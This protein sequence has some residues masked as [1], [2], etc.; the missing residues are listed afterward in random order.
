VSV[1]NS[2]GTYNFNPGLGEEI[3][4]AFQLCGIRPTALTQQHFESARMAANMV[5][6]RFSSD[7]VN[8]WQ[9]QQYS[10]PLVQGCATYP[11]PTN[12]IVMLDTYYTICSGNNEIDR[13]MMPVSRSEYAAYSDKQR[14]GAPTVYWMD[15]LLSPTVTLYATPNGQQASL[16]FYALRQTQDA[17]FTNG[18]AAEMPYYFIEAFCTAVAYRLAII[19][20]PAQAPMLKLFADEAWQK[21]STQNTEQANFYISP[22]VSGYF[23]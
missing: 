3:L 15:R 23:R 11:L 7:G 19:W 22:M 17:V 13:I 12:L 20:A 6:G 18:S 9:V 8:L 5:Q 14:Q 10:I 21:A 1:P 2:S 16:K 4:Y